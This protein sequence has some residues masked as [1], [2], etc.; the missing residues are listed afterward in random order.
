MGRA[1]PHQPHSSLD[2]PKGCEVSSAKSLNPWPGSL[3]SS[4]L[5]AL[6]HA[7]VWGLLSATASLGWHLRAQAAPGEAKEVAAKGTTFL[8][9]VGT[10]SGGEDEEGGSVT[11]L[12]ALF[13]A[14]L[15]AARS[16]S[17]PWEL[18]CS[19]PHPAVRH[20]DPALASFLQT[21]KLFFLR[22]T[23]RQLLPQGHCGQGEEMPRYLV[24]SL[25]SYWFL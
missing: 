2:L 13:V 20:S 1:K 16:S 6:S 14:A 12:L 7:M 9:D 8:G 25:F 10:R 17:S 19:L 23:K 21:V 22:C 24:S 15:P 11:F 18:C 4:L 5:A 3:L